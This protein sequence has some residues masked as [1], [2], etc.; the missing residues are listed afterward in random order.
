[1]LDGARSVRG[2]EVGSVDLIEGYAVQHG[3][4]VSKYDLSIQFRTSGSESYI[5]WVDSVLGLN[6]SSSMVWKT[7]NEYGVKVFDRV[8]G[9][10]EALRAK[11]ALGASARIIAGFCWPWSDPVKDRAL[12]AWPDPR[13]DYSLYP[14]VTIGSWARPWNRKPRDMWKVKGSAEPP[15]RHPYVIWASEPE[16]FDRIGCIYSAQGFE[17]DYV[18]VIIGSDLR[19]SPVGKYW[20]VDLRANKDVGFK[21]GVSS[22]GTV[23]LEKLKHIYRELCTRGMKGTYFHFTDPA[24]RD[25]FL[26]CGAEY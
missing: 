15:D 1:M 23:A 16:G 19:W 13:G 20:T 11:V 8:E 9:M 25:H 14:D 24:T 2:D 7:E 21:N 17:F 26:E 5:N 4:P 22:D 10:E 3:I 12:Q 18:G 6:K